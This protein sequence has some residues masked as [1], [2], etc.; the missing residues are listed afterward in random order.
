LQIVYAG[1]AV[2]V[3]ALLWTYFGWLILLAGAQLSFYI[4]NP[5]CLR[6]GLRELRLSNVEFEQLALKL[7]Y[8][9]A[10]THV[11]GDEPWTVSR[12]ATELGVPG[13]AVAAL[14]ATFEEA[15]LLI[16]TDNGELLPARDIGN[17]TVCEILDVARNQR[18]GHFEPRNVTIPS[19][20]RLVAAVEEA[21]RSGCRNLT[22]RDLAEE[23]PYG[24]MPQV[25]RT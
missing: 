24:S 1:F 17:I 7:M 19:V 4:Q 20:D 9:I 21:L 8:Y 3:A 12:L 22:L 13:K 5:T 23:A 2:I 11:S 10:R 14:V 15:G 16:G 25:A 6:L 18:S